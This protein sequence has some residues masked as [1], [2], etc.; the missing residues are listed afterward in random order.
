MNRLTKSIALIAISMLLL[1]G[2]VFPGGLI[3]DTILIAD[4][5]QARSYSVKGSSI[6][7]YYVDQEN[8][9][10]S[11]SPNYYLIQIDKKDR[12]IA[13]VASEHDERSCFIGLTVQR[14]DADKSIETLEHFLQ[15]SELPL[16]EREQSKFEIASRLKTLNDNLVVI[17]QPQDNQP[18][19]TYSGKNC[20][21]FASEKRYAVK[22][23][24]IKQITAKI[25]EWKNSLALSA[26]A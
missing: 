13:F 19:L 16:A 25:V 12:F 14:D 7:F 17:N 6:P 18:L 3:Q 22:P 4:K 11:I 2:C 5:I 21:L 15:W 9:I 1:S 10:I 20:D 24:A 26:Q 8:K 23:D